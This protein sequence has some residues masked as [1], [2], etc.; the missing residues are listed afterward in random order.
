MEIDTGNKAWVQ[1]RGEAKLSSLK[2]TGDG[3]LSMYWVDSP[4]LKVSG[5]GK[6]KVE[7]AGK[8]GTLEANL[9]D[10]AY[11]NGQYLRSKKA[12]VK[13]YNHARA[14]INVLET[15]NTLASGESDIFFFDTPKYVTNNMSKAGAVLDFRGTS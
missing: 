13:T 1:L 10:H 6:G 11:F 5:K 2:F 7:I 14:D 3:F 12:Y 15:Q 4:Y 8:V 9:Y